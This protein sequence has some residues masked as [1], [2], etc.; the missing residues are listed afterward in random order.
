MKI[1][2][3]LSLATAMLCLIGDTGEARPMDLTEVV[4]VIAHQPATPSTEPLE[5]QADHS[6]FKASQKISDKVK[7][8]VIASLLKTTD[9]E[10]Q[11]ALKKNFA[12]VNMLKNMEERI[13]SKGYDAYDLATAYMTWVTVSYDILQGKKIP[14][15]H[16]LALYN[17]FNRAI[18]HNPYYAQLTDGK[19]QVLA[20][21]YYWI[22]LLL[23]LTEQQVQ[24]GTV[25][26]EKLM[27]EVIT[28]LKKRHINYYKMELSSEGLCKQY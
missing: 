24:Q 2:R 10:Q 25:K 1:L 23:K 21:T 26:R 18:D 4:N 7:K 15:D 5:T 27:T 22:A 9:A 8:H 20:E 28:T 12:K 17:Q 16:V 3:I 6:Q 19:K 13:A 14:G 11:T